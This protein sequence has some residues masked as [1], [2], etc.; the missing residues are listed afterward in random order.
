MMVRSGP[1]S[2]LC[3]ELLF[4]EKS[5]KGQAVGP[6]SFLLL[7]SII[8]GVSRGGAARLVNT[9][10]L[11][12]TD[13]I[14]MSALDQPLLGAVNVVHVR[15]LTTTPTGCPVRLERISGSL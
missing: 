7:L 8:E 10:R 6:R 4:F 11:L 14:L 13:R 3:R 9:S 12:G 1:K 2:G 5:G 15:L